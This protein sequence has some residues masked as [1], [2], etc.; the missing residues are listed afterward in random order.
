MRSRRPVTKCLNM[1]LTDMKLADIKLECR[2]YMYRLKMKNKDVY[3][4]SPRSVGLFAH[5]KEI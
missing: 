1:K 3:N 4:K 2:Q 5:V